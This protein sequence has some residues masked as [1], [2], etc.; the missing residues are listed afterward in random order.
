MPARTD[1]RHQAPGT[2]GY[3]KR[4]IPAGLGAQ[5]GLRRCYGRDSLVRIPTC[6][7]APKRDPIR[8]SH[9]PMKWR[10][11]RTRR[12]GLDRRRQRPHLERLSFHNIN[13]L[14]LMVGGV[15]PRR[16]FTP[17]P[18]TQAQRP[19]SDQSTDLLPGRSGTGNRRRSRPFAIRDA[20]GTACYTLMVGGAQDR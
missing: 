14:R 1:E 19:V 20:D 4:V 15:P 2:R 13:V 10:R 8:K 12:W 17:V 5:S 18:A 11:N 9:N 6:A 16:R 3:C 7:S